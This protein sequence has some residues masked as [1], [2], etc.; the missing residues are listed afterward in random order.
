MG[1]DGRAACVEDEQP[2]RATAMLDFI[3]LGLRL[4]E[5]IFLSRFKARF[6][7]DLLGTIADTGAWLL[8]NGLLEFDG[9]RLRV[10]AEHQLITNEILVR[11]EEPLRNAHHV[12]PETTPPQIAVRY[13]R[14]S[15]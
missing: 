5:G 1:R 13:P 4:R 10:A 9:D 7:V 12:R 3:T 11:L 15:S 8:E 14:A 6:E 2:D